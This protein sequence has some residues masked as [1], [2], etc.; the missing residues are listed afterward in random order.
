[1]KSTESHVITKGT[2]QFEGRYSILTLP[3]VITSE[4][5]RALTVKLASEINACCRWRTR[6]FFAIYNVLITVFTCKE[7]Q[8]QYIHTY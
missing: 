7:D 5:E 3:T 4:V 8:F 2:D 6:V 1:L